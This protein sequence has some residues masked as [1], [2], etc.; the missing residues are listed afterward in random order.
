LLKKANNKNKF[1]VR[2][3]RRTK[4]FLFLIVVLADVVL[5]VPWP[6]SPKRMV[7]WPEDEEAPATSP[8]HQLEN[9]LNQHR[10][11]EE[12]E[13]AGEAPSH[14]Q[15]KDEC[16]M[17]SRSQSDRHPREVQPTR[18]PPLSVKW[19]RPPPP[20]VKPLTV[21]SLRAGNAK[22]A[23]KACGGLPSPCPIFDTHCHFDRIFNKC[24]R[25]HRMPFKPWELTLDTLIRRHGREFGPNFEG[26]V[27]V[28]CDPYDFAGDRNKRW[29]YISHTDPRV[30]LAYGCHPLKTD[31]MD[32]DLLTALWQRMRDPRVVALGEFG[33]DFHDKGNKCKKNPPRETQVSSLRFSLL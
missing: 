24:I 31:E 14:S 33:L 19:D 28:V 32:S 17:A 2:P 27:A 22:K 23:V 12:E 4:H 30:H 10:T 15:A 20:P 9:R 5:L 21:N 25:E 6:R 11:E 16:R 29:R 1:P 8:Q 7:Q 18:S 26:C 13:V 3:A